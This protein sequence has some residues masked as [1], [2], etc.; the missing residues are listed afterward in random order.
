M[1]F[2]VTVSSR[3]RQSA[4]GGAIAAT[5]PYAFVLLATALSLIAGIAET[6]AA[7]PVFPTGSRLGLVPPPA[8][9]AS[10]AFQ[11]F[12]DPGT[13][14]TIL[15]T[16]LPAAAYEQFDKSM[17]PDAMKKQGITVEHRTPIELT[18]GK[19]FVLSGRETTDKQH[20]R[21]W[22]LIASIG[23][24]TA[25][26]HFQVPEQDTTYS[27]QTVRAIFATLAVRERVPDAEQ[28]SLV[29]FRIGELAGFRIEEVVPGRGIVLVDLPPDESPSD[30]NATA[31]ARLFIAA[32]P[33]GP[34][35][36]GERDNF[37]RV[38][39]SQISGI[40]EVQLQDGGPLRIGGQPGYQILAKAKDAGTGTDVMVVQW[41]RF[42]SGGFLRMIGVARADTWTEMFGRLRSVRDS[43]N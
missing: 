41:L 5:R 16:T 35:E 24:V 22:M 39:F 21:K 10:R 31:K 37:A 17:I 29:P 2:A 42:G 14:A 40:K 15:L 32:M 6:S 18:D 20:F 26:V 11:G 33:G 38:A 4:I 19:G 1:E 25:L 9:V 23:D 30:P 7:E 13:N 27:E 28:L 34:G 43:I 8:M 36:P 3:S 12:Q